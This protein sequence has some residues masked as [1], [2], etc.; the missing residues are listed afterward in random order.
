MIEDDPTVKVD[1]PKI[2]EKNIIRLDV[3]EV[4]KLLDEVESGE[5]LTAEETKQYH[6]KTK[7]RDLAMMT[8]LLEPVSVFLNVRPR[9]GRC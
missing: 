4:A 8:L 6:E 3:D 9:Y 1:M 5:N 2:H 7:I